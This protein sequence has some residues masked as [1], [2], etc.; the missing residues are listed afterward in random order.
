MFSFFLYQMLSTTLT[1][2]VVLGSGVNAVQFLQNTTVPANLT[3][4]CSSALVGDVNCSPVVAALRSGSYY[5]QST[6]NRTCTADCANALSAYESNVLSACRGQT[7]NGYQDTEM[8][9]AIIP[10]MLRYLYNLTCL[11]DSGRYCNVV[12]AAAAQAL[13]PGSMYAC[14]P[15]RSREIFSA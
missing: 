11:M 1:F 10:D 5:P 15:F 6:L 7:W 12:S 3:A 9:L 13:D 14:S 2:L 4:A 8:P